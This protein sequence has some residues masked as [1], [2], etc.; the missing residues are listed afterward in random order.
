MKILICGL[1]GSGK[2]TFAIKL[3]KKIKKL[4][5]SVDY[6]NADEI[7]A[8]NNDWDFSIEGRIRQGNKFIEL[9]DN[10]KADIVIC[11]FIAPLEETRNNLN[12]D[13]IIWM[14][15]VKESI[16]QNFEKPNEYDFRIRN[17]TNMCNKLQTILTLIDRAS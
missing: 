12:P 17:F 16:C 8:I 10:S 2:T 7:R 13:I 3:I 5:K 6:F 9:S 11:D 14:D 15:T 1:P 4:N